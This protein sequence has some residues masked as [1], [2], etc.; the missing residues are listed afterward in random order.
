MVLEKWKARRKKEKEIKESG[1]TVKREGTIIHKTKKFFLGEKVQ[2]DE[3]G[4]I[5]S[6]ATAPGQQR[7]PVIDAEIK[8]KQEHDAIHGGSGSQGETGETQQGET[9]ESGK[10]PGVGTKATKTDV[11]PDA[12]NVLIGHFGDAI[13]RGFPRTEEG[14]PTYLW[15]RMTDNEFIEYIHDKPVPTPS[16]LYDVA[17]GKKM[18]DVRKELAE[19][20]RKGS[21]KEVN[22]EE[23]DILIVTLL[24]H[25]NTEYRNMF[26]NYLANVA[27]AKRSA[28]EAGAFIG[29]ALHAL[30]TTSSTRQDKDV[31]N[32]DPLMPEKM[33]QEYF[34]KM[35]YGIIENAV[36]EFADKLEVVYGIAD[37]KDEEIDSKILITIGRHTNA[38]RQ[39]LLSDISVIKD[40][41]QLNADAHLQMDYNI[42][43]NGVVDEAVKLGNELKG[44][45]NDA[46]ADLL[47]EKV[48]KLKGKIDS[49]GMDDPTK[50]EITGHIDKMVKA[51]DNKLENTRNLNETLKQLDKNAKGDVRT[52]LR[53]DNM[54]LNYSEDQSIDVEM[55]RLAEIKKREDPVVKTAKE[56]IEK[57]KKTKTHEG[58]TDDQWVIAVIAYEGG[59]QQEINNK[60]DVEKKTLTGLVAWL[61]RLGMYQITSPKQRDKEK[62]RE[63]NNEFRKRRSDY[64]AKRPE[65]IKDDDEK[66]MKRYLSAL[67]GY[68]VNGAA[69]LLESGQDVLITEETKRR[70]ESFVD[71]AVENVLTV[72]EDSKEFNQLVDQH[73]E[74]KVTDA[75]GNYLFLRIQRYY[76]TKGKDRKDIRK[77]LRKVGIELKRSWT[78]FER[79]VDAIYKW[80]DH[81][82]TSP[83]MDIKKINRIDNTAARWGMKT[84]FRTLQ[85]VQA[86]S[87]LAIAL[88]VKLPKYLFWDVEYKEK[89]YGLIKIIYDHFRHG[90]EERREPDK[91]GRMGYFAKR[92]WLGVSWTFLSAAIITTVLSLVSKPFEKEDS[93]SFLKNWRKQAVRYPWNYD[94]LGYY[95]F[96]A[97][98]WKLRGYDILN[99]KQENKNPKMENL[100][101]EIIEGVTQDPVFMLQ[102]Y[103]HD[104]TRANL[105]AEG[106]EREDQIKW[107]QEHP[108]VAKVFAERRFNRRIGYVDAKNISER[109]GRKTIDTLEKQRGV[110]IDE[111]RDERGKPT[112]FTVKTLGFEQGMIEDGLKLNT[113][114]TE[115][116]INKLMEL[117]GKGIEVNGNYVES[118]RKFW[119]DEGYFV[120][121]LVEAYMNDYKVNNL[122]T[123]EVIMANEEMAKWLHPKTRKGYDPVYIKEGNVERIVELI[124]E[125]EKGKKKGL[126]TLM[127]EDEDARK[128][129]FDAVIATAWEEG[130]LEDAREEYNRHLAELEL[131]KDLGL[132]YPKS[133]ELVG[134]LL[135]NLVKEEWTDLLSNKLKEGLSK[136]KVKAE[137]AEYLETKKEEL[138]DDKAEM[139]TKLDGWIAYLSGT[140]GEGEDTTMGEV[141]TSSGAI[142]AKILAYLEENREKEDVASL[143][144][145]YK[146]A[147]AITAIQLDRLDEYIL[148]IQMHIEE[149]GG[150]ASDFDPKDGDMLD[151]AK[152]RGYLTSRA[153]DMDAQIKDM[154]VEIG[155]ESESFLGEIDGVLEMLIAGDNKHYK[156]AVEEC[157]GGEEGQKLV[158]DIIKYEIMKRV[159]FANEG[160]DPSL[161]DLKKSGIGFDDEGKPELKD[162]KKLQ[163]KVIIPTVKRIKEEGSKE[164]KLP[165]E[166]VG[167]AADAEEAITKAKSAIEAAKKAEKDVTE[168]EA[169]LKKA[170]DALASGKYED[171]IEN[172][173]AAEKGAA[174][175][176]D[177]GELVVIEAIKNGGDMEIR[178]KEVDGKLEMT[179]KFKASEKEYELIKRPGDAVK[180]LVESEDYKDVNTDVELIEKDGQLVYILDATYTKGWTNFGKNVRA[181]YYTGTETITYE[182]K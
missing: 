1:G 175:E 90:E 22:R 4:N 117:E 62:L 86:V 54:K 96:K 125:H 168:A 77:E 141:P 48:E 174:L 148:E 115:D 123:A 24:H 44:E 72:V 50:Q 130:L 158:A 107:L 173:N 180:A 67:S 143:L 133:P 119:V 104:V 61:K 114:K 154:T 147:S 60:Y 106:I 65:M 80:F 43:L 78:D 40:P 176:E 18:E 161:D 11:D 9:Q 163:T 129:I 32:L 136:T 83:W 128:K 59:I 112:G 182:S 2:R 66:V 69:E 49:A 178:Q 38:F 82:L 84:L 56:V 162:P 109:E 41:E 35:T 23:L 20:L 3:K 102:F 75:M 93:N 6:G 33:A 120:P 139:R 13:K 74:E 99:Y 27:T 110:K 150:S 46:R 132:L 85:V 37:A 179:V 16:E 146:S 145:E 98:P 81:Y 156:A 140:L 19:S 5:I 57:L 95:N 29:S 116:F 87:N 160:D 142:D 21:I 71:A 167:P 64:K 51:V 42:E 118:M 92:V 170:E 137:I 45:M 138:G 39:M 68:T 105:E 127:P 34:K 94:E 111:V 171:A 122:K 8:A 108:D 135:D 88:A 53:E 91:K 7:N 166:K 26:F 103:Y 15:E 63:L 97:A 31:S 25:E 30:T 153:K 70:A 12:F 149:L 165:S 14:I 28:M 10:K 52:G 151:Y 152:G 157:G 58:M 177:L 121:G 36:G 134:Y 100:T 159:K 47:K 126:I 172:A 79:A 73:G 144:M 55:A 181:Y 17:Y 76:Q 131:Q 164:F 89:R 101:P 124:V 169:Q 113:R 155:G